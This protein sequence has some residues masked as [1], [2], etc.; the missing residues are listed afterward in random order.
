M[1]PAY[2]IKKDKRL[3]QRKQIQ[4]RLQ[5]EFPAFIEDPVSDLDWPSIF[6]LASNKMQKAHHLDSNIVNQ[7]K[8]RLNWLFNKLPLNDRLF[9]QKRIASNRCAFCEDAE[10]TRQHL[11]SCWEERTEGNRQWELVLEISTNIKR[12]AEQEPK[13]ST[14]READL[15]TVIE[16]IMQTKMPDEKHSWH[17]PLVIHR[18]T[19]EGIRNFLENRLGLKISITQAKTLVL[20]SFNE[21]LIFIY[22]QIWKPRAAL[23]TE[24][25]L[26]IKRRK[27][28]AENAERRATRSLPMPPPLSPGPTV[29]VVQ[30]LPPPQ[31]IPPKKR[32]KRKK[33][34]HHPTSS[35]L[36]ISPGLK[37]MK[38]VLSNNKRKRSQVVGEDS[39]TQSK[40]GRWSSGNFM[41]R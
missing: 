14:M 38:Q 31:P 18:S 8:F 24:A 15:V 27:K 12:K 17:H 19:P 16:F 5:K 11:L 4:H 10:K 34:K 1:Y 30:T 13:L 7:H 36:F 2:Y 40:R 41:Q 35:D 33:T 23:I 32:R 25:I 9:Q 28:Q 37:R 21:F 22:K 29:N 39:L 6:L 26:E 20:I 3:Q